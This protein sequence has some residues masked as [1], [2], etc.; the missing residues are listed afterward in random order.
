MTDWICDS[1]SLVVFSQR[2]HSLSVSLRSLEIRTN[3][4]QYPV[5]YSDL[6]I[7]PPRVA[8]D[9]NDNEGGIPKNTG[10]HGHLVQAIVRVTG[11]SSYSC[12]TNPA[13]QLPSG[14]RDVA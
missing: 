11:V 12:K 2:Y 9:P 13:R 10:W 6:D 7:M 8:A 4:P 14:S 1:S 5:R 3:R